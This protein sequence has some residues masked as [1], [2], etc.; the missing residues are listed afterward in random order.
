M[1]LIPIKN[2]N[3]YLNGDHA[4]RLT[5]LSS[6]YNDNDYIQIE[7]LNV[8]AMEKKKAQMVNEYFPAMPDAAE[9][10]LKWH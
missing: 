4:R 7:D 10:P 2:Y 1:D 6:S 5:I 3:S 8:P 9:I